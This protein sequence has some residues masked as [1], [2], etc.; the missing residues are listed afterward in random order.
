MVSF[1]TRLVCIQVER[2]GVS[3]VIMGSRGYGAEKRSRKARL[4]SVSDY[5][6]RHC[7]RINPYASSMLRGP[8]SQFIFRKNFISTSFLQC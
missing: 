5:C 6:V 3:A 8:Q 4:G 2:L 7:K 1:V